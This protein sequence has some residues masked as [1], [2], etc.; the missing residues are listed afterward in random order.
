MKIC[1]AVHNHHPASPCF[2]IIFLTSTFVLDPN[3][4]QGQ[5][6]NS[7]SNVMSYHTV[8]CSTNNRMSVAL[9]CN[10]TTFPIISIIVGFIK[11][12]IGMLL[13]VEVSSSKRHNCFN[14]YTHTWQHF[15]ELAYI[16]N[17]SQL[18]HS[19]KKEMYISDK[20]WFLRTACQSRQENI[21][22]SK[23][24]RDRTLISRQ[25]VFSRYV[26]YAQ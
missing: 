19:Q 24:W 23:C 1:S 12:I 7:V 6:N 20:A 15:A 3:T 13:V 8:N 26:A 21:T 16:Q 5:N 25:K 14:I 18:C 4:L 17:Y 11:H 9:E 10:V 22:A 2:F